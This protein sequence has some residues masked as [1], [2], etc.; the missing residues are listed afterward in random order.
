MTDPAQRR[1]NSLAARDVATHLHP[2]TNLKDFQSTGPHVIE[3]G[4]GVYIYDDAG[5]RYLEGMAGLWC[6]TLGYSERH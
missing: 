6:A 4:E 2:F 1:P 5:R 3:R